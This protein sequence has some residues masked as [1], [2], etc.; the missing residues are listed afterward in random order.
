[1][2]IKLVNNFRLVKFLSFGYRFMKSSLENGFI[3]SMKFV[4]RKPLS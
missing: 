1:M 4:A 2:I 3:K